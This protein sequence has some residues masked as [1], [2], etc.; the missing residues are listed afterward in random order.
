MYHRSDIIF[1]DAL[2]FR[3]CDTNFLFAGISLTDGVA[4]LHNRRL[5]FEPKS[6]LTELIE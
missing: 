3:E 5:I 1:A 6:T 2:K 4:M